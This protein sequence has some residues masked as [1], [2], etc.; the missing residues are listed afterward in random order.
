M[1]KT[2]EE[3]V[4][5]IVYSCEDR[6]ELAER[7]VGLEDE[8]VKLCEVLKASWG[9]VNRTVDCYECRLVAGGCTLQSAMKE[10]GVEVG[11]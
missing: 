8:S 2:R 1:G 10:V 6:E 7:I 3:R 4:F 9:C 5:N 11:A